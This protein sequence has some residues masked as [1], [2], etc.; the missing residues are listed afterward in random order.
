MLQPP[1]LQPLLDVAV[2]CCTGD[3]GVGDGEAGDGDGAT[4]AVATTLV[5]R[6]TALQHLHTSML[7][8]SLCARFP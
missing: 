7:L 1:P 8:S 2:I 5:V 6:W 4:A 3:G